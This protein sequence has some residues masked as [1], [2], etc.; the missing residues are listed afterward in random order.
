MLNLCRPNSPH[1]C[2]K[3][4]SVIHCIKFFVFQHDSENFMVMPYFCVTGFILSANVVFLM[5]WSLKQVT[6]ATGH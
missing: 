4:F 1:K 6:V 3:L 2:D 5:C